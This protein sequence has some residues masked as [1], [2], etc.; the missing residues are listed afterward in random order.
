MDIEEGEYIQR[1][2]AF[3]M[4]IWRRVM[5]ISWTEHRSNQELCD[6]VGENRGFINS[7]RQGQKNWMGHV[8]RGDSI[9]RTFWR[10]GWKERECVEDRVLQCWTG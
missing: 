2:E 8:L 4:W 5:K 10:V 7:I 6:M 9:L 1:L 3:E